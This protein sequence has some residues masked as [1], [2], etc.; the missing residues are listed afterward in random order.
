MDE[1][2]VV[3]GL[4]R[5]L[6]MREPDQ[7][8][9]STYMGELKR[10]EAVEQV[11]AYFVQSPEFR[12]KISRLS[13]PNPL[14][15]APPMRVGLQLSDDESRLL[16]DHVARTWSSLGTADPYWSVLT[17]P[18]WKAE[19]MT[20]AEV[21]DA[22]YDTGRH[23]IATLDRWF[24]RNGIAT[25]PLEV[26][27]EYGCGVGRCTVW[28]ARRF[29]RVLAF[30][31]S[32]P[33][34][35]L[36]NA[37]AQAEGLNNIEFIHVRSEQELQRLNG[38]DLFYSVIVLQHNPPPVILSILRHAF[39]GLRPGG[40]AHFQVPTYALDYAFELQE[41]LGRLRNQGMEMHFVPQRAI[42]DLAA[43]CGMQPIEVAPDSSIGEHDK[44][45]SSRFLMTRR[46]EAPPWV[47]AE[48][49][50]ARAA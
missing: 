47:A 46:V 41:Y 50:T 31:I 12:G 26:C 16:W 3:T 24:E 30:D 13:P 25:G 49:P 44:W 43:T 20:Q 15:E 14:S 11:I 19:R 4:Y 33:H 10:G 9:L 2:Q 8:G 7:G 17:N 28:L 34:L 6:L 38:T 48:P 37:R 22:F 18:R 40:I 23:D 36:A 27:A 35:R 39:R 42:F 45:I 29:R 32:E 1:Q 21:L 5:S